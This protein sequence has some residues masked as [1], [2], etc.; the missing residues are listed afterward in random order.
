VASQPGS[1]RAFASVAA[2]L[3]L[4]LALQ[5]CG[6]SE[7][8]ASRSPAAILAASRTAA[9]DASA[10]HA[11]SAVYDERADP[12]VKTKAKPLPMLT[13]ELQ[14]TGGDGRARLVLLGTESEAIRI[15]D[16]LYV[17]GGPGFDQRL[18]RLTG[19]QIAPGTWVKAPANTTALASSAALTEPMRE[20]TLLLANPTISLTKGP[21]T[22]IDGH[23]AI[24]LKTE[25]KLYTGAIYIAAS[26]TPYPL[27]IVKHGLENARTTFTGWN[28]PTQL[29]APTGAVELN[30]TATPQGG[31]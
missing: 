28:Q 2:A 23:K 18:A 30:A 17:K 6:S 29:T 7:N 1:V 19:Q 12:K 25:G 26:G 16:T 24:E 14:L 5:A 13:L 22:T 4:T 11:L 27:L 31:R 10:V 15:G 21:V 3:G 9:R 20:L 8:I